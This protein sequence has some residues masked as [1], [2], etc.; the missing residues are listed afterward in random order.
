MPTRHHVVS[1]S[2][3]REQ[4][5]GLGRLRSAEEKQHQQHT[6]LREVWTQEMEQFFSLPKQ[7]AALISY[8]C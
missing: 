6:A 3:E 7:L 5:M 8:Q 2:D 1:A 4:G